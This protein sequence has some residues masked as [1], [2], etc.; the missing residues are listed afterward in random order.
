[1]ILM[2]DQTTKLYTFISPGTGCKSTILTFPHS[3]IPAK[4]AF[5]VRPTG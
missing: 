1:M 3:F 5:L 4:L 2:P